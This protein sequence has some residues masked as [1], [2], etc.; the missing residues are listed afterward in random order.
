MKFALFIST[1]KKK[2]RHCLQTNF[3]GIV[4]TTIH[5][6]DKTQEQRDLTFYIRVLNIKVTKFKIL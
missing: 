2:K 1:V 3:N 4:L 5:K 6:Y